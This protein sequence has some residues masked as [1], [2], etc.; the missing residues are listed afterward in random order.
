MCLNVCVF[1]KTWDGALYTHVRIYVLCMY[2]HHH[3]FIYYFLTHQ[4]SSPV[5]K[6]EVCHV[7][8]QPAAAAAVAVGPCVVV[9]GVMIQHLG[10]KFIS[11]RHHHTHT[12]KI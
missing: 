1:F 8:R 10:C 5:G 11:I 12:H 2:L 7:C 9:W 4:Q 3:L 6:H